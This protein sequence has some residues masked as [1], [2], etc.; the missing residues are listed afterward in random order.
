M[1]WGVT[2]QNLV[3]SNAGINH[4]NSKLAG[5]FNAISDKICIN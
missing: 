5:I 3:P 4:K 2:Y 1:L